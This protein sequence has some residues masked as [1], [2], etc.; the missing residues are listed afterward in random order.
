M[1]AAAIALLLRPIAKGQAEAGVLDRNA[2]DRAIFRDQ[3]AELDRDLERGTIVAAEADAARNEISRRLIA[4][5]SPVA[6]RPAATPPMALLAALIV[7]LV[8]VPLYLKA[9]NPLLPDV[10]LRE[11]LAQAAETG[12]EEALIAKVELH[13]ASKPDDL[14]GWKVLVP[15]YRTAMRWADV[16]E[17][18]RNILRLSQ[19]T[20]ESLADY[21]EA[22]TMANRGEVSASA[23]DSL[24]QAL[25]LDPKL[26]KARFYDALALKQQGKAADAKAAFEAFLADTPEDAP[27]RA[28]LL[29]EM[30]DVS[31][32]PPALDRQTMQ[33]AAAMTPEDRQAMIRTM[34][35]GLE[36]K[37]KA[38]GND[39]E[40]WL[41]LI[42][43]RSVLGDGEK[44]KQAFERASALFKDDSRALASLA[45]LAKEVG[46]Q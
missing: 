9:G 25:A 36:E 10:P 4:A 37:L 5:A 46:L 18:Q 44:A 33:D 34:V 8:A 13:L 42:R 40:G 45:G 11:R 1:T 12:D 2:H 17:A 32:R 24:R 43:A 26:P 15:A 39:I 41:R 27:W 19:P 30:Q 14:Q 31:S 16:A 20:A 3:L 28:M 22:L 35:D 29:A 7:P 38:D 21:G 23:H 6:S